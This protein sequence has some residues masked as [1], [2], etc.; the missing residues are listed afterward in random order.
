MDYKKVAND[1]F[2]SIGG[3]NNVKDV[4]NCMTRI[5]VDL[6]DSSVVDTNALKSV[7]GVM[8]VIEG[9]IF[10][11]VVGPGASQKIADAMNEQLKL[12]AN[13]N[14]KQESFDELQRRTKQEIKKKHKL[15]DI[16][17]SFSNI[18]V[19]LIPAFI[20][21]GLAAGI[22]GVLQNL[23]T[24]GSI[25]ADVWTYIINVCN[26]IYKG[27]FT[28]LVIFVGINTA[29]VCGGTAALGGVVGAITLLPSMG[30]G[31]T[32]TP[33][34]DVAGGFDVKPLDTITNFILHE[35]LKAGQGGVIGV[36]LSVWLM[37]MLEK[38]LK[39]RIPDAFYLIIVPTVTILVTGFFTLFIAMP[40]A[41]IVADGLLDGINWLLY[42]GG[43][44]AGFIMSALFLPCVMLGLHQVLVPIHTGFIEKLGYTQLLPIL[45]MA[46][47][48]QIGAVLAVWFRYR[49]NKVLTTRIKSALPVAC[50]GIGEPLIYGITLP[51]GRPFITSCIGAGFG[52]AVLGYIGNVGSIAIGSSSFALIP[53]IANGKYLTYIFAYLISIAAAFII[54]FFFGNPKEDVL[55]AATK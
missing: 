50:L 16:L 3:A 52:G 19:P 11:I 4:I 34:P 35:P 21:C 30:P 36:I 1:I 23:I 20:G 43:A 24:D 5:R 39:K 28:Y 55:I 6:K 33:N 40:L 49:E 31:Y 53:L 46:G 15:N 12:S 18:F 32:V 8:G 48:G 41:G 22:A 44:F 51:L 26:T 13:S 54:T 9:E 45:A 14:E 27:I 2:A 29:K 37:C 47:A 17:K 7:D 25:N 42:V 38:W 10:Q